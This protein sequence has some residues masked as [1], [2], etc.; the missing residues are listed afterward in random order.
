L[1]HHV[2]IYEDAGANDAAHDQ[3]GRVEEA[4]SSG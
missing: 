1:R 2:R 4:Q 3:H